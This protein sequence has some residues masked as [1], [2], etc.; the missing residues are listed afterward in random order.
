MGPHRP[1]TGRIH[2]TRRRKLQH[3][4]PRRPRCRREL[5]PLAHLHH[6][7]DV[8][9]RPFLGDIAARITAQLPGTWTVQV[10]IYAHPVWQGDLLPWLWDRG[11]LVR[12][13]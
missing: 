10:E 5:L 9:P 8:S 3:A 11:E 7:T 4:R 1:G 13:V 2:Q 6:A 12:T